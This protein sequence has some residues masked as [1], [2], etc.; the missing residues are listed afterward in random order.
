MNAPRSQNC[1]LVANS[2]DCQGSSSRHSSSAQKSRFCPQFGPEGCL[3]LLKASGASGGGLIAVT[4]KLKTFAQRLS[5]I[6]IKQTENDYSHK[7]LIIS[8][9]DLTSV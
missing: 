8:I 9:S 5:F 7:I 4:Q 6:R 2:C 1:V 3:T